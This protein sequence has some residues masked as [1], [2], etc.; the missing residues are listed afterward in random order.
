MG[1]ANNGVWAVERGR[2]AVELSPGQVG[3]A[4]ASRLNPLLC[5]GCPGPGPQLLLRAGPQC[6][7]MAAGESGGRLL[8]GVGQRLPL[9]VSWEGRLE[10][11]GQETGPEV[12]EGQSSPSAYRNAGEVQPSHRMWAGG[13]ASSGESTRL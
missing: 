6:L 4:L 7:R 8:P 11:R 5:C 10:V 9:E 13:S 12:T 2:S 1:L 3:R